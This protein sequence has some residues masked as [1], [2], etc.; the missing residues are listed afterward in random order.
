MT[1]TQREPKPGEWWE[2][3]DGRVV[4]IGSIGWE[5]D[6]AIVCDWLDRMGHGTHWHQSQFVHFIA[7]ADLTPP[8]PRAKKLRAWTRGEA[9]VDAWYRP[10]DLDHA[11]RA[12]SFMIGLCVGLCLGA[13][14]MRGMM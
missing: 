10:R 14:V 6:G 2:M 11:F 9:P 13:A 8:A 4:L 3:K 7:K 1:D 12:I 5:S